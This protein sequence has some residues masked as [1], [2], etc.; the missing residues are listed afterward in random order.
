MEVATTYDPLNLIHLNDDVLLETLK[1][2]QLFDVIAFRQVCQRF[3][4]LADDYLSRK[5]KHFHI[6]STLDRKS[7]EIIKNLGQHLQTLHL[8]SVHSPL[9]VNKLHQQIL[10]INKHC[11]QLKAL[12]I[13]TKNWYNA[14]SISASA[15]TKLHFE[16]LKHLELS[17]IRMEKDL[18]LVPAFENLEVLK[19]NSIGNFSGQSLVHMRQLKTLH[20]T[21]CTQLK[22]NYLY[23]LFK[24]SDGGLQ[25]LLVHKC[26]DIDE[27]ILDMVCSHLP[28]IQRLSVIFSYIASYDPSILSCLQQLKSLS[29]HNFQSYNINRFIERV[30]IN[31]NLE[32]WEVNGENMKIYRLDESTLEQLEKNKN[33]SELS[34][35]KCNFVTDEFLMRVGRNMQLKKFSIRDC[36]G[37]STNGLM[38][39]V[40]LAKKLTHLSIKNCTIL[41]SATIDIANK[42][43]EDDE[44]PSI[45]IDYDID[46]GYRPYVDDFYDDDD[47]CQYIN[48]F[49]AHCDSDSSDA[50]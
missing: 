15:M 8:V 18:E 4:T 23:D 5:V 30:A 37:F 27:I 50:E 10:L 28:N 40:E 21:S 6:D 43:L 26:R 1:H 32:Y 38:R 2:L 35:V 13:E 7:K 9:K 12:K 48:S 29:L 16:Y 44:R 17:N 39:F 34:F 47:D 45:Q 20:L 22:P 41:R 11:T 25:E 31:N 36:W 46:C 3:E 19:L 24:N 33:L 42:V 14:I 49:D